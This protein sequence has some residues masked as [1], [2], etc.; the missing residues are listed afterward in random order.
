MVA[1]AARVGESEALGTER[2][3]VDLAQVIVHLGS[4]RRVLELQERLGDL[5]ILG[6]NLD[7]AAVVDERDVNLGERAGMGSNSGD[8][9]AGWGGAA[10]TLAAHVNVYGET[11]LVADI[12]LAAGIG[13]NIGC[14]G[15]IGFAVGGHGWGVGDG[16]LVQAGGGGGWCSQSG[17]DEG[18]D[19]CHSRSGELKL[20]SGEIWSE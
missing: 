16:S 1:E 15:H 20:H 6:R 9:G 17:D 7:A 10:M 18:D 8:G 13:C 3:A 11:A 19:G 12:S 5:A 4:G 14:W 2:V